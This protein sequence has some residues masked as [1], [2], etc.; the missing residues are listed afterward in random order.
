MR[1]QD[2]TLVR[3]VATALANPEQSV[4]ARVLLRGALRAANPE[5]LKA[6]LT[7]APL[8]GIDLERSRD[9][10]RPVDL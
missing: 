5:R 7:A 4:E 2:V 8:E 10:G 3:S 6:L 9:A 1:K